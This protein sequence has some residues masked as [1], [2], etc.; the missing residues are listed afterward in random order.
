MNEKNKSEIWIGFKRGIGFILACI[1][2][3]LIFAML[4]VIYLNIKLNYEFGF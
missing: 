4:F 1:F 2:I 3:S